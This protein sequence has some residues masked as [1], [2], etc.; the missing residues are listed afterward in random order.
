M[1]EDEYP[2]V[3]TGDDLSTVQVLLSY[4]LFQAFEAWLIRHGLEVSP[5]ML[6]SADDLPTYTVLP[7]INRD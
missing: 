6:F 2:K 7:P 1:S 3:Y 5:P 4:E